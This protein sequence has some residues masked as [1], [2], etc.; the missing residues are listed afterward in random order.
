M[1]AS[2]KHILAAALLAEGV[3]DT[4]C[5]K[6]NKIQAVTADLGSTSFDCEDGVA[7]VQIPGP[8]AA[9][10]FM[11][12][13]DNEDCVDG[14]D[15]TH[16]GDGEEEDVMKLPEETVFGFTLYL[17]EDYVTYGP[18]EVDAV[19]ESVGRYFAVGA[20][21]R[22]PFASLAEAVAAK[23]LDEAVAFGRLLPDGSFQELAEATVLDENGMTLT[24]AVKKIQVNFKGAKRIKMQCPAGFKF[25]ATD[26]ACVKIAGEELAK[27]RK[28]SVKAVVSR[29]AGGAALKARAAVRTKK[30][31]NFRKAMGLK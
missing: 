26:N 4:G 15:V 13:L 30:A 11:D 14:Y 7:H 17:G 19:E 12:F 22:G 3:E 9:Q 23:T 25:S 16:S 6:L 5:A 2:I 18:E 8:E 31:M 28:A 21:P 10:Q 27:R 24:E 20:N 29:K 1:K